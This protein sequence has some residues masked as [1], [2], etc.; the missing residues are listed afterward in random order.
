MQPHLKGKERVRKS[1][2]RKGFLRSMRDRIRH[3]K[4]KLGF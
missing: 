3:L 1:R 4:I 2:Y